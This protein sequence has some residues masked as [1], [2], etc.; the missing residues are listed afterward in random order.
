MKIRN[1]AAALAATLVLCAASAPDTAFARGGGG[2]HGGGGGFHGGGGF[3]GGGRGGGGFSGGGHSF[4]GGA[5]RSD[6]GGGGAR[7]VR[8]SASSNVNFSGNRNLSS[9]NFSNRNFS[10]TNFNNRNVNVNNFNGNNMHG[11]CYGG[12]YG[13]GWDDYHPVATGAAIGAAAAVTAAA[14][15]SVAYSIPSNCVYVNAYYQCGSTWYQ[16]QYAGSNVQ[17]VVVNPP[18]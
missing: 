13:R 11:A 5:G 4:S 10:N 16:P 1:A 14:I 7:D 12:C 17:Y 8:S 9:S 18:G 2:F 3:S 15:G 6:F